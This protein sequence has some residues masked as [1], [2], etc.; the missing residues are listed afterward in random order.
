[1]LL[2]VHRH[3]LVNTC[4][5][6]YVKVKDKLQG[7]VLSFHHG[8]CGFLTHVFRFSG[9]TFMHWATSQVHSSSSFASTVNYIHDSGLPPGSPA[10]RPLDAQF[11]FHCIPSRLSNVSW[12]CWLMTGKWLK[13]CDKSHASRSFLTYLQF[14]LPCPEVTFYTFFKTWVSHFKFDMNQHLYLPV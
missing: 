12:L 2:C 5:S 1:M 14:W 6:L 11:F 3:E 10:S 4:H 7:S 13:D 8:V 9:S